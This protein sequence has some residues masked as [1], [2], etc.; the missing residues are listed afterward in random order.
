MRKALRAADRLV[1]RHGDGQAKRKLQG[2][3]R[4]DV[5]GGV[6]ERL[7]EHRIA[8]QLAV[9]INGH[10]APRPGQ[11]P[12]QKADPKRGHNRDKDEDAK[13]Q[14]A[15]QDK[16]IPLPLLVRPPAEGVCLRLD[17]ARR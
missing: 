11:S 9:V 13:A 1:Q 7:P 10:K 17:E 8:E 4:D 12:V 6:A 15:R 14:Q 2:H 16:Q 5:E 3:D